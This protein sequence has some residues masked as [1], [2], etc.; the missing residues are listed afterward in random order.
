MTD[1]VAPPQPAAEP[2]VPADPPKKKTVGKRILGLLG[3]LLIIVV[4][5]ALK[6]GLGAVLRPDPTGDAKAGDCLA[7]K[8]DLGE[9]A[10][11]VEAEVTECSASDAKFTVLG[12][13]DG[14]SD[15]YSTACDPTFDAKLKEG[16]EGSVIGSKEGDGYLLCLKTNA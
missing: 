4:V 11:E 8:S 6:T 15:V 14:V 5:V 9:A 12:R 1:P 2:E 16:E 3:G 7:I 10:T 13:V